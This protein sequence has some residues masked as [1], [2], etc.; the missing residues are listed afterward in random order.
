VK[1]VPCH[2]V[3]QDSLT[4]TRASNFDKMKETIL[5][6]PSTIQLQNKGPC[7]CPRSRHIDSLVGWIS[8]FLT[9]SITEQMAISTLTFT[10]SNSPG[11]IWPFY[12]STD[13]KWDNCL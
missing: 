11:G 5:V 10:K 3:T 8:C 6:G 13:S 1:G 2:A 9:D 4:C 7:T 12:E